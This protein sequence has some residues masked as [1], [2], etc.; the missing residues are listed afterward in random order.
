MKGKGTAAAIALGTL[1][2]VLKLNSSS[3]KRASFWFVIAIATMVNT[4]LV[5][6]VPLPNRDYT[7]AVVAPIGYLEYF[8]IAYCIRLAVPVQ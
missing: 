3:F 8:L 1:I 4:L 7:F 6:L 2:V 5:A